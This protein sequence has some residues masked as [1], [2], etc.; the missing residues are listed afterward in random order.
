MVNLEGENLLQ[1]TY[2][3]PRPEPGEKIPI[4]VLNFRRLFAAWFPGLKKTLYFEKLPENENLKRV[5]KIILIQVYDWHAGREGLIELN[6]FEFEQFMGIYESFLQNLGEIQY[7]RRKKGRK[8]ENIFE[9]EESSYVVREVKKGP[10][11]DKL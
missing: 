11:S 5:R 4:Q 9:L 7:I 6:D 3:Y 2:Y 1:N 10:F 8:T